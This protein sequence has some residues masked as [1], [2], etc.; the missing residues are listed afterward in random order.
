MSHYFQAGDCFTA[1]DAAEVLQSNEVAYVQFNRQ[2]TTNEAQLLN[3]LIEGKKP[4]LGLR[5]YGLYYDV[6]DLRF[7]EQ[8]PALTWLMLDKVGDVDSLDSLNGLTQLIALDIDV[9]GLKSFDFIS[10]FNASLTHLK[11]GKTKSKKPNLLCLSELEQL[12]SVVIHGHSKHLESTSRLNNLKSLSLTGMTIKDVS[13]I[14]A[15][16]ALETLSL[17]LVKS[18]S[19]DSLCHPGIVS[20]AV[21]ELKGRDNIDFVSNFTGLRELKLGYLNQVKSIPRLGCEKQLSSLSI[22]E[23]KS[24]SDVEFIFHCAELKAL[25]LASE[26]TSLRQQDFS[27]LEKLGKL[28]HAT[29]GLSSFKRNDAIAKWLTS[30]DIR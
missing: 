27:D 29:I 3:T 15:I 16:R 21:E 12:E 22:S 18:D 30:L 26:T 19:F 11:L 20:L 13:F 10:K 28:T 1:K 7:L 25:Y 4:K 8:M 14:N 24:L 23:M 2:I 6:L 9:L 5:V 17:A